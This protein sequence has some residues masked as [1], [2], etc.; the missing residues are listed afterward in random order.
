MEKRLTMFLAGIALSTGVTLAQTQ[1]SGT[2]TSSDDGQP[3]VGASVMI[4]GTKTGTVTDIDGH[5]SLDAKPG[6]KLIISYIGMQQKAVKAGSNMKIIMNP[7]NKTLDDVVVVAYGTQK[8]SSF[9]GSA[10]EMKADEISKHVVTS[11]TSALTG[12]V[13]GVQSVASSGQPG[14]APSIRIRGIGSYAASSSPLYIVDGAPYDGDISSINPEDIQEMTVLKDAAS[15]AIYGARGANGVVII[16][17]KKARGARD[18][19][20]TFDAKWGSNHREIPRYDVITDPGQYYETWFKAMYN[21][22]YMHGSTAQEAYQFAT[23]NLYDE[24]N[25]G[26]GYQVYTVPAGENLIGT[27]FKL[28]PNAKLGYSDGTYYYTPDDYYDEVN[29]SAFRQEYNVGINGGTDRLSYYANVGFLN[30]GGSVAHSTY[31]RYT[32]RT[33]VE[34]Q[35][36]KWFKFATNMDYVHVDSENPSYDATT[37]G[38]STNMFDMATKIAPIYPLYVRNADGTIMTNEVGGPVFDSNQ[39]NFHRAAIS[40][41]AM[42]NNYYDRKNVA[43]NQFR[44]NWVATVTPVD[45]LNLVANFT[46]FDRNQKN[47]YLYSRFSSYSAQDGMAFVG[48]SDMFS[49]NQIYTA[50]YDKDFGKHSVNLLAGYEHYQLKE[51]SFTGQKDHLFDPFTAELDNALAHA[52]EQV[53]SYSD[54][55]IRDGYFFRGDYNY[56]ERYFGEFS[57]RR[58]GSSIFAPGHR[59]GTFWSASAGWMISKENWFKAKWVDLLKLKASYGEQGNDN[60]T[61]SVDAQSFYYHPWSDFY[62]TSYNE[63]TKEYSSKLVYKGNSDLTWE[64]SGEWNFGADFALFNHRV[65]GSLEYFHKKTHDLLYWKTLPLSSG[66]AV[67]IYPINIGAI[68]NKGVEFTINGDIIKTPTFVWN[69]NLNLSSVKTKFTELDSSIG[70]DGLKS[71]NRI[72]KVGKS[73]YEIYMHRYAGVDKTTGQPLFYKQVFTDQDGNIYKNA[74]GSYMTE[75]Q[76]KAS[77]ATN[78]STT[79]VTVNDLTQSSFYDLGDALPDVYGGFGMNF[80]WKPANVGT[81]DLGFQFSYQLGGQVYDGMYQQ[82]MTVVG[83]AGQALSKDVLKAWDPVTNPNSNIPVLSTAAADAGN[84]GQDCVDYYLTSSDYLNLN[85][86]TLGYTFPKSLTTKWLL[87]NFR[88]YVAGENLFLVSARK[89]LDPRVYQGIGSYTSGA[90]LVGGGGYSAMRS[91]TAGIQITF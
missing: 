3:V 87:S 55:V 21:S 58:D 12:N 86:V 51:S 88:I 34:Y 83:N 1:I 36:K 28:N 41:N 32:G 25:G 77:G 57:L 29:K 59:W 6:A 61:T 33:N 82:L 78:Y 10:G 70:E 40:G 17:T 2:V 42:A 4:D 66:S 91:I 24:K 60:M 72:I 68:V 56:A 44:G 52:N 16:T 85:N 31:K 15:A 54:K 8:R 47:N 5:F 65:N 74:D 46:V 71:S 73:F 63:T 53:S 43:V 75:S 62:Q 50:N 45:G 26:L 80:T 49:T 30:D 90:A 89:G 13:A 7:D 18:A 39:T 81:F 84:V 48:T 64:K 23:D 67:S 27:N 20:I 79:D 22:K 14:S 37:Y 19:R 76:V 35:V 38:G 69:A 11:A 9:T